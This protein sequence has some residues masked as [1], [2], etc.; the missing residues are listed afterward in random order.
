MVKFGELIDLEKPILIFF[1]KG[2]EDPSM[3]EVLNE[4]AM[5]VQEEAKIVKIDV[6]K[7]GKLSEALKI[8][9]IPTAV[10]YKQGQMVWR[11]EENLS[12]ENLLR[13][14]QEYR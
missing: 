4:V 7:N 3:L 9:A 1:Y 2:V 12:T 5:E 8:E 6:E 14:L 13:Q 11:D 10:I